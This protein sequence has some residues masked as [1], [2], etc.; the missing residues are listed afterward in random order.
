MSHVVLTCGR[1]AA[2]WVVSQVACPARG[3]GGEGWVLIMGMQKVLIFSLKTKK[4][5]GA[6]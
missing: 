4:G 3:A 5:G 6:V 2:V 1:K